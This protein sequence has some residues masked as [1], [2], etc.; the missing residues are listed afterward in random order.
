MAEKVSFKFIPQNANREVAL[1]RFT[2]DGAFD[3][4]LANPDLQHIDY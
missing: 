3:G 2:L 4:P 1:H